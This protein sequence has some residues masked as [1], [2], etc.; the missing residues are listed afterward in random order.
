MRIAVVMLGLVIG[1]VSAAFTLLRDPLGLF[2][3]AT[4]QPVDEPAELVAGNGLARGILAD[5]AG[6]L[7]MDSAQVDPF[8]DSALRY[9]RLDVVLLDSPAGGAPALAV[10]VAA[11][12]GDNS[13]LGGRLVT[14][15]SWNLMWPGHG[16][17]F[18][19]SR[20]DYRPL[21]ADRVINLV[22]GQGFQPS[23]EPVGM[24]IKPRLLGAGGRLNAT[25]GTYR[26]FRSP[27]NG[28]ELELGL[29]EN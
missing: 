24:A 28:T 20:D 5:P 7:G 14:D 27:V 26:E 6:V 3:A 10:K 2:E 11:P 23:T 25:Q 18:L 29:L 16:S 13:L 12:R 4:M 1:A 15:S 19:S 8:V 9:A 22:T 21:L 17:L